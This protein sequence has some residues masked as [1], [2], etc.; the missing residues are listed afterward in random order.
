MSANGL[1]SRCLRARSAATALVGG[2][3]ARW[4]PPMPLMARMSARSA[5]PRGRDRVD[6]ALRRPGG[7]AAS[8]DAPRAA[9]G[10]AFG[11]A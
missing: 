6:S 5:Q 7:P 4:Y 11:W 10:Q 2:A 1:S 3:Q 9:V 8:T